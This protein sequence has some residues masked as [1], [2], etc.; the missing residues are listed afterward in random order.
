[1][2]RHLAQVEGQA[3]QFVGALHVFSRDDFGN[4]QVNFG[5]VIKVDG[6]AR[7]GFAGRCWCAAASAAWDSLLASTMASTCL[8]SIRVISGLNVASGVPVRGASRAVQSSEQFRNASAL[9]AMAG[10][11]GLR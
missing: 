3:Q 10:N 9:S 2:A 7:A 1:M 6:V 4:P 5:E 8:M 11:T